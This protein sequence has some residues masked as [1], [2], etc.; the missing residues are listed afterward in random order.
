MRGVSCCRFGVSELVLLCEQEPDVMGSE[1]R[2]R[3]EK[4]DEDCESR[5]ENFQELLRS[6]WIKEE[7]EAEA[8]LKSEGCEE[9]REKVDEA[10]MEEIYEFAATQRKLLRGEST[11]E[12]KEETDRFGEDGPFSAQISLSVQVHE[13][14]ENAEE[15]ELCDQRRDEAPVKWKSVGPSTPLR[16]KGHGA[17]VETAGSPEEALGRPGSSRPSRGGRTGRKEGAF[18]CSAAAAAEQPFSSTPRRC[19]EPSQTTSELQ[20][21]DGTATRKG[22]ESPC[23]PAHR[24]SPPLRPC[25]S[26]LLQG[27]SPGR[28]RPCPRPHHTGQSPS[29]AS[30]AA[31]QDSPSKQRRGRSL[32]KL[33]KDPGLQK[34]KERG[35]LLECR[36]KGALVSPEKSP[37]IDLTQ[38]KPGHLSSRSQNT[39]SSKNREDE[40]ILLLDSDEELEL[41]QTKTKSVLDGPL[42]ERKVLEVST[43]SSELFSVIDVDADQDSFQSPPRREAELLCGEE[44]PPGSQGSGEGRGTPQLFCDPESGPEEDSTTDASWLVPATPLASRSRDS[45]SQTQITGL[46]SRALVDHMAQFKPWAS[47]E[48]RDRPEAA[49]TCSIAR[50]QMS[51][52]HL[53]PIIAGSPDSRGPC[54][55]HPGRLQHFALLA[56]CPIS[57][58]RADSTGQLRK[59]SPLGPS[60]LNQA[61]ASEVVEVED[62]EDEREVAN[63]SPLPDNDPPIPVDDCHW[64]M[65]PLSPIPID[66]LNLELTGPLSTSSPSGYGH[67]PAL[68]GTTPNRGSLAAQRKAPEK[69]PR[70]GSPGSS[71]Q[72]FL[73][74]A[75]W[76]HWDE[77]EQT[78]PELLPAAQTPSADEAQKSEGLETPKGAHWKNLPP[79]VPI[80]PMPRYSIM[81]TP[82]LKKELDRFGVRPLPKRQMVLKL[83]EIFQYTHQTLESD[84]EN[85]SQSSRVLLEAPHSQTQASKTSKGSSHQENPPGGSLP[86]M[87]REEPP[88]PDGDVQ[89]PAS[90][91]SVASSVDSSDGSFNSQSSS[92][93][94]GVALESAGDE[95]GQEEIS[96]SQTAAQ[97]AATEEAVRRYIRSRPALYRKVL[98]YQP[99]ELAELQAELK[100]HGI[101]MAL[102]KLLDF[103]DAHCITFTTSAARKEKLQRK[104]RQ[105]VGKKKRGRAAG[106]S[107][108]PHPRPSAACER[109]QPPSASQDSTG[110]SGPGDHISPP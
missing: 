19:P 102:G 110:V 13:Q 24:Q 1:D 70:A 63:S 46:R 50:P 104:R 61:T 29:G 105:P 89:L 88:G 42:E 80:T 93:E 56:A 28:P 55:P 38:S 91:E 45:S 97:A 60:L 37:S 53:G 85:E 18:W 6:V 94:F 22:E 25:L 48:N 30:R 69:S 31:S 107:A 9:D 67:S 90:Q 52:P 71:R 49:N 33:L 36:N 35:S 108:P 99:F 82:V 4:E 27:R 86:P 41:E 54:S 62:S 5:A 106:R 12:V 59:R 103:L 16:L 14:P 64:H 76:D 43:K 40:I 39:P 15:M 78:S 2:P 66:R 10:E 7:E 17:D 77:K 34:G 21:D 65:E 58:G 11:P 23:T 87:S 84:S 92:F 32:C 75:L 26:K 79:K 20:E 101:R 57:G 8:S 47:L 51:P 83:K 100:Q 3:K 73:N 109:L 44:R 81:E 95:E 96:A 74:S 68:S 72:S 98:L